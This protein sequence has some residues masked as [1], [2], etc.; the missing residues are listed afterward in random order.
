MEV[1]NFYAGGRHDRAGNRRKDPRFAAAVTSDPRTVVLPMFGGRVL[2]RHDPAGRYGLASPR[3]SDHPDVAS[4]LGRDGTADALDWAL[5]GLIDGV[6]HLAVDLGEGE[7]D[8]PSPSAWTADGAVFEETR[9]IATR[10][11]GG[12]AALVA[13]ARGLINWRRA[14][15]F[16]ARCGAPGTA[17]ECG[18]V[19]RCDRCGTNHFPRTDPAVIML[20]RCGERALLA[21][22]ARYPAGRMFSTLAGFVEPGESLEEAVAREVLEEC[23]VVARNVT[24]HSSQPWPFPGSIML[25]FTADAA[26]EAVTIDDDEILEARY[27]T[28]DEIRG[29]AALGLDLP[30]RTSIAR[31]LIDDWIEAE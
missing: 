27:F 13:Q 7:A 28:R 10:I 17:V 16:C 31:R 18:H 20:I 15:R 11:D 3:L 25:G 4:R 29:R 1:H 26:D 14:T 21:R 2:V 24:Y 9:R 19:V 8:D 22:N 12:E 6:A 30:P 5:L 23:G